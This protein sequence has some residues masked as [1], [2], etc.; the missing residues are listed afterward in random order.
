L[1]DIAT[2]PLGDRLT[3]PLGALRVGRI[4]EHGPRRSGIGA[5][6]REH[7]PPAHVGEPRSDDGALVGT[8]VHPNGA[9]KELPQR[10]GNLRRRAPLVGDTHRR[11]ILPL[12]RRRKEMPTS[13]ASA[14]LWEA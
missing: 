3:R 9:V 4:L 2:A 11:S 13:P 12:A 5:P 14:C 1:T 6:P 10:G 7:E 8:G